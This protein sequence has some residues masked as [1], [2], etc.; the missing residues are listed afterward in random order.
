MSNGFSFWKKRPRIPKPKKKPEIIYPK[1]NT[2]PVK[3][4]KAEEGTTPPV[5][6]APPN[7]EEG[8]PQS[9]IGLHYTPPPP[10]KVPFSKSWSYTF[11]IIVVFTVATV[12][13][14]NWRNA[15]T[16]MEEAAQPVSV[17]TVQQPA[18]N[19]YQPGGSSGQP[20]TSAIVET[21][22]FDGEWVS[23]FACTYYMIPDSDDNF[24]YIE[25]K[26]YLSFK[27]L[28]I[29]ND[30]WGYNQIQ[31]ES[32]RIISDASLVWE[33]P[34]PVPSGDQGPFGFDTRYNSGT[35]WEHDVII[36]GNQMTV[37]LHSPDLVQIMY[38][39]LV[40]NDP[41]NNNKDTLY[42]TLDY[43]YSDFTLTSALDSDL[44]AIVLVKQ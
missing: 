35:S 6:S 43:E 7:P 25:I 8:V 3:Y 27:I 42:L 15:N 24:R 21:S 39:T 16:Q 20:V 1:S 29:D 31:L 9:G 33:L 17:A 26:A 28:K 23:P 38:F 40:K 10:K 14:I 13:V 11:V 30:W 41:R 4:E 18:G 44:Q 19:D 2:Q 36:D 32:S 34:P 5:E 12:Y 37:Y 22:P